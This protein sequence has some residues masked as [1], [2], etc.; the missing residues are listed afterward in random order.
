MQKKIK[1][2]VV[3]Y[4]IM[5]VEI[6]DEDKMAQEIEEEIQDKNADERDWEEIEDD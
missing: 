4:G 2:K 3:H 1:Y 5:E 6:I